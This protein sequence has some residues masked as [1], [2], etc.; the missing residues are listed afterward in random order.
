MMELI[1]GMPVAELFLAGI[2]ALISTEIVKWFFNIRES[3]IGLHSSNNGQLIKTRYAAIVFTIIIFTSNIIAYITYNQ[4]HGVVDINAELS[5]TVI[6]IFIV[7]I[8]I[9]LVWGYL[10]KNHYNRSSN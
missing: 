5:N 6:D 8:G 3:N 2:F 4:L 1:S 9:I 10:K 7:L